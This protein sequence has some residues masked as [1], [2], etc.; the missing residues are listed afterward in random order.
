M[1]PLSSAT[2]SPASTPENSPENSPRNSLVGNVQEAVQGTFANLKTANSGEKRSLDI[3]DTEIRNLLIQA[4][5]SEN[6]FNLA[7]A[8]KHLSEILERCTPETKQALAGW[9]L[10]QALRLLNPQ[11]VPIHADRFGTIIIHFEPLYTIFYKK[12]NF[13]CDPVPFLSLVKQAVLG[14]NRPDKLGILYNFIAPFLVW[15]MQGPYHPQIKEMIDEWVQDPIFWEFDVALNQILKDIINGCY[16]K[17][18]SGDLGL[19]KWLETL[20]QQVGD[21]AYLKALAVSPPVAKNAYT[22]LC[23]KVID[24]VAAAGRPPNCLELRLLLCYLHPTYDPQRHQ[25]FLD[26]LTSPFLQQAQVCGFEE[27]ARYG[28]ICHGLDIERHTIL[29]CSLPE[30]FTLFQEKYH[31]VLCPALQDLLLQRLSENQESFFQQPAQ[32]E[33]LRQILKLLK[34][35]R[36]HFLSLEEARMVLRWL[37]HI[38]PSAKKPEILLDSLAVFN[39]FP[40]F[41]KTLPPFEGKLSLEKRQS[42]TQLFLKWPELDFSGW[43]TKEVSCAEFEKCSLIDQTVL[44]FI[45]PNSFARPKISLDA[46]LG[47][48]FRHV[49][50]I[51]IFISLDTTAFRKS[52]ISELARFLKMSCPSNLTQH[53]SFLFALR[54]LVRILPELR[55]IPPELGET[56]QQMCDKILSSRDV[57]HTKIMLDFIT[58][59]SELSQ[60]TPLLLKPKTGVEL[61]MFVSTVVQAM[62]EEEKFKLLNE[63]LSLHENNPGMFN[64]AHLHKITSYLIGGIA[65]VL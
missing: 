24:S 42:L 22:I 26:R 5:Q 19:V 63:L 35:R 23:K 25:N 34:M 3:S 43:R 60:F 10:S 30:M 18:F 20:H 36:G 31:R 13:E 4:M 15:S 64:K 38:A 62:N 45:F 41:W 33:L 1:S 9:F 56:L 27:L 54:T 39:V 17:Q 50:F 47:D 53:D 7:V 16:D 44:H 65:K 55:T 57:Q 11:V 32:E 21:E 52:L 14:A 61:L 59:L 49:G 29:N 46:L 2:S 51:L 12:Q 40:L 8:S 58:F 48:T 6:R 28:E 37:Q